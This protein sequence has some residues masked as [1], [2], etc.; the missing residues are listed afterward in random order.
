MVGP[1]FWEL[2]TPSTLLNNIENALP[3]TPEKEK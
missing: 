1:L 2:E 3:Q